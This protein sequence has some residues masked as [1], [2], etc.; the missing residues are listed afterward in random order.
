[1]S[2]FGGLGPV[3][4]SRQ[5]QGKAKETS[6]QK[7]LREGIT[8]Y[9]WNKLNAPA[10]QQPG[11]ST[12]RTRQDFRNFLRDMGAT[13]IPPPTI[14]QFPHFG[15]Y[16]A[17]F[18]DQPGA[19]GTAP[20]GKSGQPVRALAGAGGRNLPPAPGVTVGGVMSP[21]QLSALIDRVSGQGAAAT[22]NAAPGGNLPRGLATMLQTAALA[23]NRALGADVNAQTRLNMALPNAEQRLGSERARVGAWDEMMNADLRQRDLALKK[24]AADVGL[25]SGK[26]RLSTGMALDQLELQKQQ[27]RNVA[28]LLQMLAG[29]SDP[30][31]EQDSF[32][33]EA[34]YN[35]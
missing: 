8:S 17:T 20:P 23:A 12:S 35:G 27:Q 16:E 6:E 15:S 26:E 2:S 24:W 3:P 25:R 22:R 34:Y 5:R 33:Q 32:N 9:I 29:L 30:G 31:Q 28:P 21:E 7:D 18:A 10:E 1:M 13:R 14:G 19:G 4:Y 11:Q